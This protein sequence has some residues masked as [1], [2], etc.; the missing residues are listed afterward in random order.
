[1]KTSGNLQAFPLP[2]LIQMLSALGRCAVVSLQQEDRRGLLI[3]EGNE[4]VHADEGA[5]RTTLGSLL[6]FRSLV[7]E[8]ELQDAL[9]RRAASVGS[10][11]LGEILVETGVLARE[12]IEEA[13]QEHVRKSMRR[14]LEWDQGSFEFLVLDDLEEHRLDA[15]VMDLILAPGVP[16]E[17][18]L[19]DS[20]STSEP[21][22]SEPIPE[23]SI[24]EEPTSEEL[25]AEEPAAEDSPTPAPEE[26]DPEVGP[27]LEVASE[28]WRERDQEEQEEAAAILALETDQPTPETTMHE[29]PLDPGSSAESETRTEFGEDSEREET[30]GSQAMPREVV[31]S[32]IESPVDE[33]DALMSSFGLK[34]SKPSVTPPHEPQDRMPEAW[35]HSEEALEPAD[36]EVWED[37]PRASVPETEDASEASPPEPR[38]AA[39][40]PTVEDFKAFIGSDPH[41][42]LIV[43][44]NGQ[45]QFANRSMAVSVLSTVVELQGSPVSALVHFDDRSTLDELLRDAGDGAEAASV[46][47]GGADG[48]W[49]DFYPLPGLTRDQDGK[50]LI[51]LR[52]SAGGDIRQRH[53]P[54]TGLLNREAIVERIGRSLQRS[55]QEDESVFAVLVI[56]IDRF[57]MVNTGFGWATANDL[58]RAVGGRLVEH[59][60]PGDVVGRLAGDQFCVLLDRMR[61]GEDTVLVSNRII[62]VL[63]RPFML[64]GREICIS[65]SIG[66]S[67]CHPEYEDAEEM[68]G[69]AELA[70]TTAKAEKGAS[71]HVGEAKPGGRIRAETQF[72]LEAD[73]R[74]GIEHDEFTPYFQPIL[75]LKDGTPRV[76]EVLVRWQ[77]P[78]K[79]L[80][81]PGAFLDAAEETGLIIPIAKKLLRD[82]CVQLRRWEDRFDLEQ[83][84][85]LGMNFTANHLERSEV[86]NTLQ[87]SMSRSGVDG[88]QLV[89][90]VT[91]RMVMQHPDHV[92]QMLA[93]LKELDVQV[94][95]DDFGVEYSSLAY[96][97]ELPVDAIKL[98]RT[99]VSRIGS[100]TGSEIIVRAIIDLA[101]KLGKKVVGEGIETP[102][103]LAQMS[104]LGSDF[105]QGFLF[106]RPASA[107]GIDRMLSSDLPWASMFA[108]RDEEPDTLGRAS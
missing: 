19:M 95:L 11:H 106:A 32:S 73:I 1:M 37:L 72:Q 65:V 4:V 48:T 9:N 41:P 56:D 50:G 35:D 18:L 98:D 62:E 69:E 76:L 6:L 103:Q 25:T 82:A 85:A 12:M 2:D 74:R 101:H 26:V 54:L 75:S 29:K 105:G 36:S 28:A 63:D 108:T 61:S 16:S 100:D 99:F 97:H 102:E 89:V 49:K 3:L 77:H 13:S 45:I 33:V 96:L 59:L 94:F 107:E 88:S 51:M 47:L 31:P 67:T 86:L 91:E 46:R 10:S 53:D 40:R 52:A 64:A 84:L 93:V 43:D 38:I 39:G 8:S 15:D 24:P 78:K 58:L 81:Q 44:G 68:V 34:S 21:A 90:E 30:E 71:I 57:K 27:H 80:L 92:L 79:G 5:S 20:F 104:A 23:E 70:M 22:S 87:S 55:R 42:T 83:P 14:L 66:A 7:S 60:R 17:V